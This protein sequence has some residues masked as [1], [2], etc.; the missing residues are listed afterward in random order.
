[1]IHYT[2]VYIRMGWGLLRLGT[3]ADGG[4]AR[5]VGTP[6]AH[7]AKAPSPFEYIHTHSVSGMRWSILANAPINFGECACPF[8]RMHQS[9]LANIYMRFQGTL[10]ILHFPYMISFLLF[11][12]I[13]GYGHGS[14]RF[15]GDQE[16]IIPESLGEI[17]RFRMSKRI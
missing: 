10:Y 9:I 1:M 14:F 8:Y 7:A 4:N 16:M 3:L 11:S 6:G 12:F 17:Y 13:P 5:G 15:V 2:C